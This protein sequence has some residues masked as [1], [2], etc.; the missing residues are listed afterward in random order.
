MDSVKIKEECSLMYEQIRKAQ[1][2]LKE[3]REMCKHEH[4]WETNYSYRIGSLMPAIVCSDCGEL[5]SF[6][7]LPIERNVQECD[8][9]G[10][11]SSTSADKHLDF[12]TKEA[13]EMGLYD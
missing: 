7:P 6:I 4:Y 12:I 3:L 8:A 13:Q 1:D 9:T 2:R 5:I 11:D 10:D